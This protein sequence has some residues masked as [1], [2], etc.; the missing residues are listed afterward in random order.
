MKAILHKDLISLG[1]KCEFTDGL[2]NG[3][4][5]SYSLNHFEIFR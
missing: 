4:Y 5:L 2:D 3:G 1:F